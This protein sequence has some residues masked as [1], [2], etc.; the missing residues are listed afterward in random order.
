MA[1]GSANN[2]SANNATAA[3]PNGVTP[4]LIALGDSLFSGGSCQRCHGNGG[5]GGENGPSL[6]TGSWLHADGSFDG[7]VRVITAG[8][9]R[10]ALKDS[11]RRPMRGRGG[12]MNLTDEHVRAVSAY[13]WSISRDKK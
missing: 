10:E 6:K 4:Q 7:L 5:V 1:A 13:V 11:T 9:P 2:A 8:V 3:M 12:P